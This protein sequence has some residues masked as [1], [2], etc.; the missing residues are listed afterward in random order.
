VRTFSLVCHVSH[1]A[2]ALGIMINGLGYY[3][4]VHALNK[5]IPQK[6]LDLDHRRLHALVLCI[7]ECG[8]EG[9][10]CECGC[11][12]CHFEVCHVESVPCLVC[13]MS[14]VCHVECVPCCVCDMLCV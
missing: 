2:G 7:F 12:W 10:G 5:L 9:G 11:G 6:D 4:W 1:G 13:D 14:N 3:A 8:C